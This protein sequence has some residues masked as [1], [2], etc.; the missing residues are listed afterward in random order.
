MI[1]VMVFIDGTW[2]YSNLRHLAKESNQPGF[3]VDYGV[4]PHA[5]KYELEEKDGLPPLDLVR[6]SLFGSYPVNYDIIDEDRAQRRKDFFGLLR[7]DYH[8]D[9]EA[10]PIDY[11]R[12]R[13]LHDDRDDDDS[14]APK[15]KC[16]DIAVASSMLY[17]ASIGSYDIAIAIIGDKD[18][19]PVLQK[20]RHL[21]KRVAIASIRQSCARM[22]AENADEKG[23]KDFH[24]IWLNDLVD[25]IVW[26]P[27]E[28]LVDCK[29][30]HHEGERETVTTIRLKE[31]QP[32]FCDECRVKFAE[33]KAEQMRQYTSAGIDQSDDQHN[34]E[35]D[36]DG[37]EVDSDALY[38]GVIEN[39]IPDRGYGF[40][41][42][43]DGST[44]FFHVA[45]L[46]NAE[47]NEVVTGQRVQFTVTKNPAGGKAGST[48]KVTLLNEE[49]VE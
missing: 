29:S 11:Q 49:K 12:H 33:Q 9:V 45:H 24:I 36:G 3:Y 41:K 42:R 27:V 2:L 16:V 20:V 40:V 19:Y 30:P 47:W 32:F 37:H 4:L 26:K 23:L 34:G 39:M 46:A 17:H 14:F 10:F 5:V 13:I 44:F 25:K 35:W 38:E 31:G 15:E 18:Y 1:K 6:T 48:G 28:T 21:G 22:Y 43:G 8:Y 7:E